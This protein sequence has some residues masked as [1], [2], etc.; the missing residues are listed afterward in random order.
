MKNYDIYICATLL[1][2][3]IPNNIV[4]LLP[5]ILNERTSHRISSSLV[6][7]LSVLHSKSFSRTLI[8]HFKFDQICF[9]RRISHSSEYGRAGRLDISPIVGAVISLV[10]YPENAQGLF[11]KRGYGV[12]S[13][14]STA[15]RPFTV[16]WSA[17]L[18]LLSARLNQLYLISRLGRRS[19]F[20]TSCLVAGES[21]VNNN[22]SADTV[23]PQ[24][25]VS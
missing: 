8:Y 12:S 4:K 15:T 10:P 11:Y 18:G 14:G 20:I 24:S 3:I 13:S 22:H 16:H 5:Q 17:A 7:L 9:T 21:D 19:P 1:K 23:G 25:S 2:I 6:D